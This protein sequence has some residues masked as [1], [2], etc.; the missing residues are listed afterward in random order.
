MNLK[1]FFGFHDYQPVHGLW[2]K[3]M[4]M[5][6]T[7]FTPNV[8]GIYTIKLYK[9]S[10]CGKIREKIIETYSDNKFNLNDVRDNLIHSDI[11][12]VNSYYAD[13]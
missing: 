5:T 3:H 1:C 11:R 12:H 13:E 2:W 9:C 6:Y 4:L 10:K 8:R 7:M